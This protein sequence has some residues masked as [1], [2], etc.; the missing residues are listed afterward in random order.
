MMGMIAKGHVTGELWVVYGVFL[1]F[2]PVSGFRFY[3]YFLGEK[4]KK[5]RNVQED[6]AVHHLSMV[7]YPLEEE[8]VQF[9]KQGRHLLVGK[10]RQ[11]QRYL[12]HAK[13]K[14]TPFFQQ[15]AVL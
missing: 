15:P 1:S 11:H 4:R 9:G 3:F 2:R 12:A 7:R 14:K 8:T 13:R 10:S 6:G 5:K